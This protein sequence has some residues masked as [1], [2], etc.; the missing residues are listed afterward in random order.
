[1]KTWRTL[2]PAGIYIVVCLAIGLLILSGCAGCNQLA[3]KDTICGPYST[4][5]WLP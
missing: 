2:L 5:P 3:G 4:F 1:M